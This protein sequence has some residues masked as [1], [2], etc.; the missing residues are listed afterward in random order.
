MHVP[1]I[2]DITGEDQPCPVDQRD[3]AWCLVAQWQPQQEVLQLVF[4]RGASRDQQVMLRLH[5]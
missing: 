3:E 2:S 5:S 4:F 1:D